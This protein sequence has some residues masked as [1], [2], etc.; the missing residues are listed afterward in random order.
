ML[1]FQRRG[2]Q[3]FRTLSCDNRLV[4]QTFGPAMR[5]LFFGE[6]VSVLQAD[7]LQRDPVTI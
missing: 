1:R 6:V 5:G 7:V 4:E 3:D 2:G